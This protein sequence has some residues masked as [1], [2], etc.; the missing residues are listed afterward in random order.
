MSMFEKFDGMMPKDFSEK[1]KE[2]AENSYDE[3]PAGK[4]TAKIEKME[5][6]LTK[7]GK[8]PMFKVQMRLVDGLGDKESEF[9]AKFKKNKPCIF[10]NR[11]VFGTKNDQNM[12]ASVVTWLNKLIGDDEHPVVFT[13]YRE[14]AEEILD[15]HEDFANVEIDVEYDA[16]KFNSI[17]IVEVH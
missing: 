15:I 9:I 7:D 8:R 10:M 11:V 12:I 2:A 1:V 13:S 17:S 4:Y 6:G 3:I 5:L 16:T 14:L